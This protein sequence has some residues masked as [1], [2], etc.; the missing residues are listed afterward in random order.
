MRSPFTLTPALAGSVLALALLSG[1]AVPPPGAAAPAPA[2][3]AST[4]ECRDVEATVLLD[5]TTQQ[6]PARA[7]RDDK[8][9][10][11]MMRDDDEDAGYPAGAFIVYDPW[12]WGYPFGFSSSFVI[13]NHSGHFHGNHF[14]N[15]FHGGFH[16]S[17]GMRAR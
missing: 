2:T 9:A 11:Q 17:G 13:V 8:G 4:P 10:W 3:T 16:S 1:C 15:G 7:C 12:L 6:L 14:H 5:G